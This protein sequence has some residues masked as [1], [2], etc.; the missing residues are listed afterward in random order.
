MAEDDRQ[1]DFSGLVQRK[2]VKQKRFHSTVAR[3]NSISFIDQRE[4]DRM[5]S[6]L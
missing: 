4:E 1:L 5:H 2:T 3:I 6:Y